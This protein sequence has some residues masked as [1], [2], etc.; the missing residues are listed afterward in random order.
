MCLI[1][2]GLSALKVYHLRYIF[3]NKSVKRSAML[4][5]TKFFKLFIYSI[6][7][8]IYALSNIYLFRKKI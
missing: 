3:R 8:A 7:N 5:K 6:F 2:I 1:S 4:L